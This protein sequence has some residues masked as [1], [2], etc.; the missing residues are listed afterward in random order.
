MA[1]LMTWDAAAVNRYD[2][3]LFIGASDA[4]A[5]IMALPGVRARLVLLH[6]VFYHQLLDAHP[7]AFL[8]GERIADLASQVNQVF[9][10]SS[11]PLGKVTKDLAGTCSHA[12]LH[13]RWLSYIPIGFTYREYFVTRR[14]F[15]VALLGSNARTIRISTRLFPRGS[16][17]VPRSL[18]ECTGLDQLRARPK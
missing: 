5:R 4:L 2:V 8:A 11:V 7:N 16:V 1:D 3:V 17:P 14:A 15:D 12:L 9:A 10:Y 6:M 18:R 13:W